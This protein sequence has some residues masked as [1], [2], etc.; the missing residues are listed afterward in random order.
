M[1]VKTLS[2]KYQ[3]RER[4]RAKYEMA[5]KAFSVNIVIYRTIKYQYKDRTPGK[6][7]MSEKNILFTFVFL[8]PVTYYAGTYRKC[9]S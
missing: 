9:S 8:K 7:E 6:F 3:Y 5:I 4:T 1:S 2:I